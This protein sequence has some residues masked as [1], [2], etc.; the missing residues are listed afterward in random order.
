MYKKELSNIKW[1]YYCLPYAEEIPHLR[2][3]Y[4]VALAQDVSRP[5]QGHVVA[6]T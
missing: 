3:E 5:R 6:L 4:V 1:G 2:Q